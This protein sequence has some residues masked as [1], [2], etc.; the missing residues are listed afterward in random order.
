MKRVIVIGAGASGMMAAIT[1]AREGV[2]VTVLEGMEKPGKKLLTTGN[3]RCNLSNTDQER[4]DRFRGGNSSIVNTVMAQFP[5]EKTMTFFEE[6][7]LL[8]QSKNG[9]LYPYVNQASAVLEVLLIEARRLHVRIKCTEKVTALFQEQ[10]IWKVQTD[11]WCYEAERVILSAG[12]MAAPATGSDGSGYRLARSLG[13][14]IT[15]PLP[16]LVPL[17]LEEKWGKKMAGLRMQAQVTLIV[18]PQASRENAHREE[19]RERGELQWT[20]YGISG[21][22]VFQLSR[23]AARAL[24]E[25]KKVSARLDL[26]PDF[27][28]KE[29]ARMLIGRRREGSAGEFLAGMLPQKAIPVFLSFISMRPSDRAERITEAQ[30]ASL[31]KVIKSLEVTVSGSR[32]F[33]V[34]QVCSGGV[35]TSEIKAETLESS[36]AS[37]IYFSGELLDVDGICGGYNLQWAWSSGYVAGYHSA[38]SL[39]GE[40]LL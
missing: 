40:E 31:A 5:L 16:A 15:T 26:M 22:V 6:L 17:I 34:A 11:T 20:E 27:S 28:E 37:G 23:Y 33:D 1:A 32:S 21:I 4:A 2:Y 13:H 8:L 29:V 30:M 3:G 14:H 36:I 25:E 24:H 18:Q 10:Q 38:H 35:D 9:Y 12:S 7:G 39:Q 19:F